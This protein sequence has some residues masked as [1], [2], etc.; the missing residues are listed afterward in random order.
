[1][2]RLAAIA[3][4]VVVL[5]GALHWWEP[6]VTA[7]RAVITSTPSPG[8]RSAAVGISVKSRSEVCVAPVALDRATARAQVTL[9]ASR[10]GPS[11]LEVDATAPGYR[12]AQAVRPMLQRMPSALAVPIAR[13]SRNVTG[14][15][16]VR[17]ESRSRLSF[18]G[19]NDPLAIGLART[20]IDGKEPAGEAIELE[21]LEERTQ[22]VLGRLGAIVHHAADFTGNLMPFWLAWLLVVALVVG[23][24]F[25]IFAAY[26]ATLRP[27]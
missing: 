8:P 12:S 2:A 7:Q 15:L 26:W 6:F 1:M 21:L 27:E 10:P 20:T 24:P 18:I 13:P 9:S 25:A 11:P 3:G 14:K 4:L 19:T 16:C 23:T 22:S 5:I 17:N